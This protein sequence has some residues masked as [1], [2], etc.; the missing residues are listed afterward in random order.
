VHQ[1]TVP[2][3]VLVADPG[4]DPDDIQAIL[5]A[6]RFHLAGRLR[7]LGVICCGG[8]RASDRARLARHALDLLHPALHA[9]PVAIGSDGTAAEPA[10]YEFG[11][12]GLADTTTDGMPAAAA[13]LLTLLEAA[14]DASVTVQIQAAFTDVHAF[15]S[16]HAA[17]FKRK[18]ARVVAMGGVERSGGGFAA[19]PAFNNDLD[20]E[21]ATAVYS[22]CRREGVP[23][24]VVSRGAV[25]PMP[26]AV[27]QRAAASAAAAAGP[28]PPPPLLAYLSTA[29]S[30]SLPA[31][32][33]NICAGRMP[34]RCT[35]AWF[36]ANFCGV[37]PADAA[38]RWAGGEPPADLDV[39]AHLGDTVRP[40]DPVTLLAS[41]ER[42]GSPQ[43]PPLFD[44]GSAAVAAGGV[45]H[46]FFH[47]LDQLHV[48]AVLAEIEA[49][50]C[51]LA[52]CGQGGDG[53]PGARAV[54]PA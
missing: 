18:V 53:E 23:L 10:A 27:I 51:S 42:P 37:S 36:L 38:V 39:A 21:A 40:Y 11:L 12:T 34:A 8:G 47:R 48:G 13:L 41:L 24:T 49:A 14:A 44:W 5:C 33:A 46:H 7:L 19:A 52:T 35:R 9:V 17:M 31:L 50:L 28:G 43:A 45:T 1:R 15:L 29:Q 25:P 30:S 54:S 16:S 22:F 26:K 6:G 3:V 2:G 20:R 4:P 32:Y